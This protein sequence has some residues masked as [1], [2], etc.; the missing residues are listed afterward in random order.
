[1]VLDSY[2]RNR[3]AL[4][5]ALSALL[6]VL[7]I[8]CSQLALVAPLRNMRQLSGSP[9]LTTTTPAGK[10]QQGPG[11]WDQ[12]PPDSVVELVARMSQLH[13]SVG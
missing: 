11:G 3:V 5:F 10:Q 7:D 2:K 8:S 6:P 9:S 12:Q 4:S 13:A 1:M